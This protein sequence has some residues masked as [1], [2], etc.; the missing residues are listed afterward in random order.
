MSYDFQPGENSSLSYNS[1]QAIFPTPLGHPRQYDPLRLI[2]C[3]SC[4]CPW[5]DSHRSHRV[6]RFCRLPPRATCRA[7]CVERAL[8]TSRETGHNDGGQDLH[9]PLDANDKKEI[10]HHPVDLGKVGIRPT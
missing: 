4:F 7:T 6:Y 2:K 9:R 3:G 1:Y 10:A 5:F 8:Q